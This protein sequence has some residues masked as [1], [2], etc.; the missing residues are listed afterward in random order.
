MRILE[1]VFWKNFKAMIVIKQKITRPSPF[2]IGRTESKEQTYAAII[3]HND[4]LSSILSLTWDGLQLFQL[5]D[6]G[7]LDNVWVKKIW[8]NRS[9]D[10]LLH[11][12]QVFLTQTLLT[13][14]CGVPNT[15]PVKVW[16]CQDTAPILLRYC[17]DPALTI[18]WYSP[19]IIQTNLGN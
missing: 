16:Y 11:F 6:K 18:P 9:S 17:S 5:S 2:T 15:A 7:L 12:V 10:T 14:L 13:L 3:C 8:K 1:G 19:Y 4:E